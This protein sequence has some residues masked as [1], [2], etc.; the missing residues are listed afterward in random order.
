MRKEYA[1]KRA[2]ALSIVQ[3]LNYAWL[4]DGYSLVVR[5]KNCV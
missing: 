1:M 4:I 5:K 3:R 2:N